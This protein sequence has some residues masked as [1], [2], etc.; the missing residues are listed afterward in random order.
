MEHNYNSFPSFINANEMQKVDSQMIDQNLWTIRQQI[1]NDLLKYSKI[2]NSHDQANCIRVNKL[3]LNY[4]QLNILYN[5]LSDRD[6]NLEYY[7]HNVFP[8]REPNVM[9][10]ALDVR[11]IRFNDI[12]P[13]GDMP[14][15]MKISW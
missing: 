15:S 7:V 10:S 5:E 13:F 12:D 1:T 11:E 4:K 9:R 8:R 6:F 14:I 2:R 3:Q